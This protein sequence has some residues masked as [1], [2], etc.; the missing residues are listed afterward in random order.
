MFE[1]PENRHRRCARVGKQMERV[2]G[3]AVVDSENDDESV[4]R[5]VPRLVLLQ[6]NEV[7]FQPEVSQQIEDVVPVHQP[8]GQWTRH[9]V[10]DHEDV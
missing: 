9:A 3:I 8:R 4:A 2:S 7:A 10:V 6:G 5:H 1:N